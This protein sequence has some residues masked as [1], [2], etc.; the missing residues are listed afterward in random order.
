MELLY[1]I[2]DTTDY[3]EHLHRQRDLMTCLNRVASEEE[4]AGIH[5]EADK[6]VVAKIWTAF[7]RVFDEA[8]T[9]L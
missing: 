4:E 9:D 3:R 7:P 8:I 6:K 5:S 2:V 1:R